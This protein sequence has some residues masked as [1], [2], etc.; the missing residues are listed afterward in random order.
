[1]RPTSRPESTTTHVVNRR[2]VLQPAAEELQPPVWRAATCVEK[3]YHEHAAREHESHDA[4][5]SNFFCWKRPF[6]L[7]CNEGSASNNA[8]TGDSVCWNPVIFLLELNFFMSCGGETRFLF[9]AAIVFF[10]GTRINFC[11]NRL[12]VL[13]QSNLL[14]FCY[15]WDFAG[16]SVLF[17]W[18]WLF[19]LLQVTTIAFFVLLRFFAGSRRC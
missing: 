6:F 7:S 4:G 3:G 19:F 16:T 14:E 5:T 1:M 17:G 15:L 12:F 2:G 8:T 10:A 13:L 11:W 9:F 18:N